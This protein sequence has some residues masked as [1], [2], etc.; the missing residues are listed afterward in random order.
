[1]RQLLFLVLLASAASAQ[2]RVEI[3]EKEVWLIRNQQPKQL[4]RDGRSKLQV[5]Y[6]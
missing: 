1:M 4:T 3:R 2:V 6:S 5:L